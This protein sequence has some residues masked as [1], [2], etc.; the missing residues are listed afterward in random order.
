MPVSFSTEEVFGPGCQRSLD[1]FTEALYLCTIPSDHKNLNLIAFVIISPSILCSLLIS[2]NVSWEG[3]R[4][5]VGNTK[6]CRAISLFF[7]YS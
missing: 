3:S 1:F 4:H 7:C 2:Q 6:V 5:C